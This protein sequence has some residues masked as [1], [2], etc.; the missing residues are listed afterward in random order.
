MRRASRIRTALWLALAVALGCHSKRAPEPG[1]LPSD[2]PLATSPKPPAATSSVF[3]PT[4]TNTCAQTGHAPDGMV[5]IPGGEFSMGVAPSAEASDRG[6]TCANPLA[7]AQPIHRVR[8]DGFWMDRTEVTNEQFARFVRATGYVTVAERTPTAHEFPAAPLENLVAGSVIFDPPRHPVPLD[9]HFQWWSYR[10]RASW[11]HP[12]GDG[13]DLRGRERDPVVHV[14][15]EDAEAYAKWAGKRLPTEAEF[16][17][18]ARGG[19]SGK[20]Y[21]WGDELQPA[22]RWMAN[23]FQGH[24]PDLDTGDDGFEGIA[25]VASFP[26]N[27]YGLYDITGNVWEWVAD[28]Y[29]S[30]YYTMLASLGVAR[31][32]LG[33]DTS[34]DPEDPET[35]KRVQR[36][37]SFLCSNQYC[38]RY[39]VG[40][41]GKG[42]PS[43]GANHLGFR[44]VRR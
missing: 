6:S 33:P 29:R 11:R 21:A 9:N 1:I 12:L 36:G 8:V 13:S 39:L 16:E 10:K 2:G 19:L 44:C 18:A 17:F 43:S 24:F 32:P 25:P 37:G 30:D 22:G 38:A 40:S 23:T 3:G 35:P 41:R 31:N 20:L 5:W 4:V 14:A 27:G 26:P 28:W 34:L 7:D 42:E 15:F